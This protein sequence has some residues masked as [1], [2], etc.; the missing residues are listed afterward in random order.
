MAHTLPRLG[1][2]A[3]LVQAERGRW[4]LWLPV[5]LGI[6]VAF[7][8]LLPSEPPRSAGPVALA[9][10]AGITIFALW[11]RALIVPALVLLALAL[12]F[13][14]AQFRAHDV[15]APVLGEELR[16]RMVS[17]LVE[18]VEP[19]A[20]GLR[21]TF[22]EVRIPGLAEAETPARLRIALRDS[23][24]DKNIVPGAA[25]QI[26]ATL[27]PPPG[28]SLPGGFDY[29]R[30]AW[31]DGLG[32]VGYATGTA[33]IVSPAVRSGWSSNI[34]GLRLSIATRLQEILPGEAGAVAVALTTGLRGAIPDGAREAMRNS[35]LAHLLAISGLHIGLVAGFVF[36]LVRAGIAL[37]PAATLRVP[38]KKYAAL[39]ALCAA[40]FYLLIAGAPVP[41]QRAFL[42]AA[43]VLFAVL[44]DRRGISMRLVAWAAVAILLLRPESLM[45][46]SFQM[47]FAAVIALVAV[48]EGWA[49]RLHRRP[50]GPMKRA[51]QYLAGVAV[52]TLVASLATAPFALF[53]FNQMSVYSLVANLV[54]VPV[55]ALW[56][57]PAGV[58]TLL[59]MPLGLD[60][61]VAPL[62]GWGIE[63]VLA[64]ARMV[65]NWPGAALTVPQM[66]GWGL[67]LVA[68][69]GLW[70]CLWQRSWRY[71]GLIGIAAGILSLFTT[72]PPDLFVSADGKLA[73]LRIDNTLLVL[74]AK[75][76]DFVREQWLDAAGTADWVS[77]A[78]AK[79]EGAPLSCDRLGCIYAGGAGNRIAFADDKRALAEDCRSADI[80]IAP[81]YVTRDCTG[82]R[83]V[84][85]WLARKTGGAHAVWF[86]ED[87]PRVETV[88]ET[89]TARLWTHGNRLPF[90]SDARF[91]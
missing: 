66:P 83:L 84:I 81:F 20:K 51:L 58:L 23:Q 2:L 43:L 8:F 1:G 40:G 56:V 14:A 9:L 3:V 38:A 46:A 34:E 70:L 62:F 57:M 48:Y 74:H 65:A 85:D 18:T 79:E 77:F 6:G 11:R 25:M 68:A 19:R 89:E 28:P 42:M 88:R 86:G 80:L 36:F 33:E 30:M 39:A 7:Y 5:G 31:F 90:K 55:A 26:R 37:W 29:R 12:G 69:G 64:T 54:A 52:T 91:Q 76:Q 13:A 63:T 32:A 53:H 61:F 87:G 22:A 73:A 67:A 16:F 24:H 35:G 71:A 50:H 15:A 45:S 60:G 78:Q 59:A 49:R 47:S 72:A 17:G 44:I 41:T 27:R 10:A 4:V 21:V 75:R 82:P